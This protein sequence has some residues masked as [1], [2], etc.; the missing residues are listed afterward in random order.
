M[1]LTAL[2]VVL[3]AVAAP[4]AAAP[5][6]HA[7]TVTATTDYSCTDPA[8]P[9]VVFAVTVEQTTTHPDSVAPGGV[10]ALTVDALA[11]TFDDAGS[12]ALRGGGATGV[13]G[14]SNSYEFGYGT[15]QGVL[16]IGQ[17]ITTIG[18][19]PLGAEGPVRLT[20]SGT[21]GSVPGIDQPVTLYSPFR[22]D[23]E[24]TLTGGAGGTRTVACANATERPIGPVAI[25]A[26]D[27][28]GSSVSPV[29]VGVGALVLVGAVL[30]LLVLRRRP[31]E[32][33]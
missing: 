29:L 4:L 20:A 17:S 26:A 2:A 5:P 7:A 27:D 16:S 3:L 24:L 23:L 31:R 19:Q 30:A 25:Q 6:A 12:T 13:S 33:D 32:E 22:F 8:A 28:T 21:T 18:E 15:G 1:R 14:S 9:D 11:L 10:V